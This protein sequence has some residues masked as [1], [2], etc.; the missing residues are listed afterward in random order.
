[1]ADCDD[2]VLMLKASASGVEN[3]T[4]DEST[5]RP[6]LHL[7]L[8]GCEDNPPYGPT[9]HT[10]TMFLNLLQ[11]TAEK[12]KIN[13]DIAIS[14]Y[15]VQQFEYPD[16]YKEFDGVILPG[17]F[18]AAYAEDEWIVRLKEVVRDDLWAKKVP[19]LGVC[20][21]H[22]ILAHAIDGG[23]ATKNPAGSQAGCRFLD[24]MT[25][26]SKPFVVDSA[27]QIPLL[28]TH[29]DMV[30]KL[31]SVATGLGGTSIVPIQGAVYHSPTDPTK[32]V[33]VTFQAHP[34]YASEG[35]EQVT[36]KT[37]MQKME[38]RGAISD[39][40]RET[41]I[42]L[43]DEHWDAIYESSVQVLSSTCRLLEWF[44]TK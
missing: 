44:P 28:Y 31:P 40:E 29:G 11:Q 13:L 3:Q 6:S 30:E 41:A 43:V 34:E 32:P 15:R 18:S 14:V 33:F 12:E 23:L 10:A 36:L 42:K 1:M 20:F 25:E 35:P 26:Q 38:E 9:A 39:A 5:T 17:S 16:S 22:Q 19:T 21:G 4:N 24:T 37:I 8:L 7:C 2:R 27:S